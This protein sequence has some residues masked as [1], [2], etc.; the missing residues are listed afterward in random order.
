M[1]SRSYELLRP[2]PHAI[3]VDVGCGT[4]KTVVDLAASGATAVGIDI[5]ERMIDVC[6]GRFADHDFRI[7]RA[8]DLPFASG[9]V[10]RYRA[11][12]L[13]Q[14]VKD[15][16]PALREAYRVL[17]FD[18]RA[19]IVDQDYDMWA[20]DSSD[21]E[22]MRA[23]QRALSDSIANSWIGRRLASLL[24]ETGFVDVT[25]E[26]QTLVYTELPA[27]EQGLAAFA[28][29]AVSA[30]AAATPGWRAG[31]NLPIFASRSV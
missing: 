14:H 27:V 22:V 7:G 9:S 3:A 13:Y 18:G 10:T 30:A 20:I 6:R 8:E 2:L 4:G 12:R 23:I 1:Q 25:V 21:R 31:R 5:S 15:P 11:E 24:Q 19:V 29:T 16:L 17:S 26:V 28:R